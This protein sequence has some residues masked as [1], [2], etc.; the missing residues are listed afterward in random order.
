MLKGQ[1][2]WIRLKASIYWVD[3][4][5][6]EEEILQLRIICSAHSGDTRGLSNSNQNI[7][8]P[9]FYRNSILPYSKVSALAHHLILLPCRIPKR[10]TY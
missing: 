4:E 5:N 8:T 6:I 2:G 10:T 1:I 7:Q 9:G 3:H